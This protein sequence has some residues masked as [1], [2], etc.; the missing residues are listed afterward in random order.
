[1]K[2]VLIVVILVVGAAT[3]GLWRSH[4]GVRGLSKAAGMSEDSQGEARDEIRKSFELQPGA[5]LEVQGINGKVDI[6]TSDTKTA[7]VYVLRTAKNSGS[8]TRREVIIEQT[9]TG[10]LV[11]GRDA[12]HAGFWEH[13]FGSNLN[14]EVTIKAP[15]QI[16]LA[17]KGING[18]VTTGDIDG[19]LEAKGINGRIELGQAGVWAEI[20][21]I[22]GSIAV[23]LKQLGE[24]GASISSVN[25]GIELRL[26][27]GLNADLT[28]RGMNGNVRSEI[29][30]VTVDKEEPG[31]R[32]SAHI[33]TGGA[34]ITLS[35]INGNVRLTRDPAA[36]SAANEKKPA[37]EKAA[38]SAPDV[39]SSS[40][41]Q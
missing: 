24:R 11:R 10:L 4:G 21:G 25:G 9:A 36:S 22:N 5:R 2:R 15:R 30:D 3:L 34:P 18:R 28:A 37:S 41:A 39:K 8:L 7:E 17:L 27:N 31:S 33:G 19:T 6:Q 14:E 1:M 12:R 20:S 23:G 13:L 29:A 32:Y 38:K 26:A 16:A 35:G 40:S